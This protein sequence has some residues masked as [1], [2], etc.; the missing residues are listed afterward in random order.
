MQYEVERRL[1]SYL[2]CR[3][4]DIRF[5]VIVGGCYAYEVD[6]M[7]GRY[8]NARF[9]VFEASPRYFPGLRKRF[10]R[11]ARVPGAELAETDVAGEIAFHE[12][13][14]AG[15]RSNLRPSESGLRDYGMRVA[16]EYTVTGVT[17]DDYMGNHGMDADQVD[18]LWCDVQGAEARVLK[19]AA[20][21]LRRCRAVFLEVSLW[22]ATYEGGCI[23]TDLEAI[24]RPSGFVCTGLG[25]DSGNGTG[26]GLW[27][28]PSGRGEA[29]KL[30]TS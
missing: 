17:L 14:P 22:E 7:L 24:L 13:D 20:D 6:H 25:I 16:E 9:L 8:P 4:E 23:I 5:V 21:L 12:T 19:G 28:R 29:G 18:L 26:N 15:N 3:R 10:R 1:H 30:G 27:I 2:A 11:Q